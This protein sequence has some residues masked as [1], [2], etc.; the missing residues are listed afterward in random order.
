[1]N[2]HLAECANLEAR[3]VIRLIFFK[4][5]PILMTYSFPRFSSSREFP[6]NVFLI[7]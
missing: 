1:M 6:F 4:K 3:D 5:F 2:E 7:L